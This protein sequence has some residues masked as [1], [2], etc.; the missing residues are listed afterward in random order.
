MSSLLVGPIK[1]FALGIY[2]GPHATPKESD[3]GPIFLGIKNVTPQGT[4]DF[5]EIRHVSE[6]EYPRW[7]KRV[8]PRE[9]DIVFSYEATL[10]RYALI[11]KEFRGCLGRR[12]ALIRP[13][14]E[15]VNPRFLH[16]YFLTRSW[17]AVI[18]SNIISGA[19]VDRVP[20][21]RFPDLEVRLPS[22]DV[23]Q[24]IA[25]I[26]STYDDLIENNRRRIRLLE[27][28]ARLLYREWF[29]HLRFPG[30]ESTTIKN[31]LPEGWERACI[32][33]IGSVI[34]GK[35][36]TKKNAAFYGK[37]IPFIKTPDMHGNS[38]V[39]KTS[40]YLSDIGA[41][42]QKNKTLPPLSILVS[43]IGTVGA[44]ALNGPIAQTNQQINSIVPK[45]EELRYWTFFMAKDL[46]PLLERM[47]GGATMANV[48]KTK[49]SNIKVTVPPS[50]ILEEFTS[51]VSPLIDQ[52]EKLVLMNLNLIEARDLLLPRLMNG[53]ITV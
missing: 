34:T 48:N 4:L 42:S 43:C 53:E 49:F 30:H 21:K 10:H 26:L 40:E 18:E 36:P 52:I 32:S 3:E 44:V 17:R 1:E 47:S 45:K 5:S 31:G 15:M 20:L 12:M 38:V 33:D 16:Y 24:R 7:T 14:I 35:T 13:N 46:K 41:H 9:N 25:S 37:D 23:Q 8:V 29:V 39:I 11:P 50:L 6:Q 28:A 19:T 22:L 2:D 27:Q 51:V